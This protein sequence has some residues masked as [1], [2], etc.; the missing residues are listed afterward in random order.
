MGKILADV[1]GFCQDFNGHDF[2]MK[3]GWIEGQS[4][5]SAER[6]VHAASTHTGRS[7]PG[8]LLRFRSIV[9]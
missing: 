7:G 1:R 6:G 4:V 8:Y 2:S 5:G 9:R 3:R